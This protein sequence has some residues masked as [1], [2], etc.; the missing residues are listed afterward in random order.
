MQMDV[1]SVF[2][3]SVFCGL[4]R[5]YARIR[6]QVRQAEVMELCRLS[7][8]QAKKLLAR[9]RDEERSEQHGTRR[10]AFYTV[11]TKA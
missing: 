2:V 1:A 9:L 3:W 6:T 4:V 5:V 10:G 7:E 11:G 8:D